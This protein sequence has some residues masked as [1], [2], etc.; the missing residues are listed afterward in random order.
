[1]THFLSQL[2]QFYNEEPTD[3]FNIY[4]LAIEYQK[5][6]IQKAQFYFEELLKNYPEYT[7]TYY[8][9][10]ALYLQM[11]KPEMASE[12]FL[13]GL[14]ITQKLNKTHANGELKRAYRAF[15]DEEME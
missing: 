6:D 9:A 4:A 12:V 10:S 14:E 13:K 11:N 3:P 1:M 5:F 8:H 2:I 15:L 7:A